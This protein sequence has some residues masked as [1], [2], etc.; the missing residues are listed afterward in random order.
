VAW[1]LTVRSRGRVERD[2]FT[3][4]EAALNTMESRLQTLVE[5]APKRELDL[6]YKK[7]EP[8]QQVFARLELSGPERL[9]P[10]IRAGID[11]R[12]D[13]SAEPYTGRV[14]RRAV[15]VRSGE[16]PGGAL[17]RVVMDES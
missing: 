1:T 5:T 8:V 15:A 13:G 3:E 12:G 10:S 4:V 9:V 17:R 6:H 14:R 11:V 2:H 16:S 7:L